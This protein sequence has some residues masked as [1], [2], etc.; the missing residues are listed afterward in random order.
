MKGGNGKTT[1]GKLIGN[2]RRRALGSAENHCTT[3]ASCLQDAGHDLGLIHRVSAV[4]DLLDRVDGLTLIIGIL[5][6]DVGRLGH[7]L[8]SQRDHR[9]G[10]GCREKHH[11]TVRGNTRK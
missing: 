3:A 10:H 8:A 4:N 7:E 5:G 6:A 1:L 11:V 9:A 2:A